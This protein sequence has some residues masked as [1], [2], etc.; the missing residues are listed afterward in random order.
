MKGISKLVT[1]V[2][3]ILIII[4]LVSLTYNIAIYLNCPR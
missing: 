3:I 4:I 1:V 2:L